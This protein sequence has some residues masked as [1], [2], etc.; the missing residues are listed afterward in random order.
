MNNA[1]T[2]Y[3][4]EINF[5]RSLFG[6]EP[7]DVYNDFDYVSETIENL[8][9]PEILSADGEY[10]RAEIKRRTNKWIDAMNQLKEIKKETV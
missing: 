10:S 6:Q 5:K 3:L 8:G 7:L 1:L 2:S 4:D 9:S